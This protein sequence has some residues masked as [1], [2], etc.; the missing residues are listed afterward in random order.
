MQIT[1]I[2]NVPNVSQAT[3]LREHAQITTELINL[4]KANENYD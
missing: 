1:E 3:I 2:K 4:R